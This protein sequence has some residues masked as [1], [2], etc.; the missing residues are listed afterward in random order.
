MMAD[1]QHRPKPGDKVE[2]GVPSWLAS[3]GAIIFGAKR[4]EISP[5]EIRVPTEPEEQVPGK[6]SDAE[7][8]GQ[9]TAQALSPDM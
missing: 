2:L 9:S 7:N 8:S 6:A 4:P 5:D 1:D 3:G